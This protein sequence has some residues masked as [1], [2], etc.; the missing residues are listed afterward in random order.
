MKRSKAI[1]LAKKECPEIDAEMAKTRVHKSTNG[2][3]GSTLLTLSGLYRKAQRQCG[4]SLTRE[5]FPTSRSGVHS[6]PEEWIRSQ[7]VGPLSQHHL[8]QRVVVFAQHPGSMLCHKASPPRIPS[9]A[10]HRIHPARARL[11]RR[12][13][14]LRPGGR[15]GERSGGFGRVVGGAAGLK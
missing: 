10:A 2:K 1:D 12:P 5:N 13:T 9:R 6:R 7:L 15:H 4:D 11:T 8:R 3:G 14:Q